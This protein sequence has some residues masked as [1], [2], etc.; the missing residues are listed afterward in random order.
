MAASLQQPA[1]RMLAFGSQVIEGEQLNADSSR[2]SKGGDPRNLPA[3]QRSDP[4]LPGVEQASNGGQ[5]TAI[6]E[7]ETVPR[8]ELFQTGRRC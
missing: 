5:P 6:Q 7:L 2:A 3:W 4:S 1:C 8:C